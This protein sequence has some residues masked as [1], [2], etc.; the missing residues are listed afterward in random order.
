MGERTVLELFPVP[1]PLGLGLLG[2]QP[3]LLGRPGLLDD[4]LG[5]VE[6]FEELL[7]I[8]VAVEESIKLSASL[9]L[10][11]LAVRQLRSR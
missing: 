5:R 7:I 6:V 2:E 3:L 11:W 8:A 1:F 4:P 10:K 9:I